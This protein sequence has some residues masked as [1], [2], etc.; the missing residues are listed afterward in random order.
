MGNKSKSKTRKIPDSAEQP[1]PLPSDLQTLRRMIADLHAFLELLKA[2]RDRGDFE[3]IGQVFEHLEHHVAPGNS[4]CAEITPRGLKLKLG[5]LMA[6]QSLDAK[7]VADRVS[8]MKTSLNAW[9]AETKKPAGRH[10]ILVGSTAQKA[11][12]NRTAAKTESKKT[13][14][15]HVLN[16][17][18]HVV[19]PLHA[20]RQR[21][22]KRL[23]NAGLTSK[24]MTAQ[25]VENAEDKQTWTPPQLAER[26]HRSPDTILTW[27]RSGELPA[28]NVSTR[29]GKRPRY[30][31]SA[32]DVAVFETKR[33]VVP[34]PVVKR[35]RRKKDDGIIK[36]F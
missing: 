19:A 25:T 16:A 17:I 30:Q 21:I 9:Q 13:L 8:A 20:L 32:A 33:R 15:N 4:P 31:I 12:Y 2:A 36:Y 29:R 3:W 27:I 28:V 7:D 26:W 6:L 1:R 11:H 23:A 18:D 34:P 10:P 24:V 22:L 5:L 35:S 14:T